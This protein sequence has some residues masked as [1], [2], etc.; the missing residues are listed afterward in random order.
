MRARG[1]FPNDEAALKLLFLV[2]NR[3]EKDWKMPPCEWT[4]AKAQM[5]V[6]VG[7]RFARAMIA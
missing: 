2:L 5:A 3:A 6:I 4:A 7:E 1:H